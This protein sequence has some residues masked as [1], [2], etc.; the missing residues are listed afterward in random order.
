M[1]YKII[2]NFLNNHDSE[3]LI[4][5]AQ[6]NSDFVNYQKIHNNR[7]F[8]TCSNIEFVNLCNKSEAWKKLEQKLA[9]EDFFKFC[10]DTLN[11]DNNKFQISNYFKNKENKTYQKKIEKVGF[12]Q[13]KSLNTST[14]V[15]FTFIRFLKRIF[16]K[17]KFS[18]IF[19]PFKKP[20][21]LLYDYSVA[22]NGYTREIHRDS[23]NRIIVFL[24]YLNTLE[25][26]TKGGNLEI[27]KLKNKMSKSSSA[28]PSKDECDNIENVSPEA[29]KLVIFQNGDDS[30]HSVSKIE[31]A[32][33]K[34]HFIY[35]GFTLLNGK[36]PYITNNSVLKTEFHLYE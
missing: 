22:G 12:S 36:N 3:N 24:L 14:I 6:S 5:D 13:I 15:K 19:F 4:K 20:V 29:G 27:F 1:N 10:C 2:K 9:S 16:R 21:E 31:N 8:L 32:P 33:N 30:F 18:K 28:K 23:D 34:R 11:L 7:F 25:E 17:I 26:G 35:G